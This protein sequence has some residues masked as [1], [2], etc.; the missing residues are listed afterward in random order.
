MNR[1]MIICRLRWPA[2]LLLTGVLALLAQADILQWDQSWPLYL[3]LLGVLAL[4]ERAVMASQPPPMNPID[5]MNPMGYPYGAAYP[6][7]GYGS[8]VYPGAGGV[9]SGST[10]AY[11]PS[12]SSVAPVSHFGDTEITG[13]SGIHNGASDK[14]HEEGR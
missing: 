4:A 14:D 5:P 8:P 11:T 12:A 3:I 7:S 6:T 13:E 1:Y 10:A 9:P 2:L